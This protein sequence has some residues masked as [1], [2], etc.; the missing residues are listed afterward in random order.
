MILLHYL[1]ITNVVLEELVE[2]SEANDEDREGG[3]NWHGAF[4][5]GIV[6]GVTHVLKS[7][8]SKTILL[9]AFNILFIM[10]ERP[11]VL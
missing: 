3:L 11:E 10:I 6:S 8:E 5:G 7:T 2:D 1:I 9:L 4:K